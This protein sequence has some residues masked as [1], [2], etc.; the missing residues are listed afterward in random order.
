MLLP[1]AAEAAVCSSVEEA[2]R[3]L[4]EGMVRRQNTVTVTCDFDLYKSMKDIYKEALKYGGP[5]SSQGVSGDYLKKSLYGTVKMSGDMDDNDNI[6][7]KYSL[8]YFTTEPQE[9]QL[10]TDIANELRMLNL[11][12]RSEAEKIKIIYDDIAGNVKYDTAEGSSASIR[13]PISYAA[14]GAL[15]HKKAVCQGYAAL[16]YRLCNESGI[17]CRIV[18]GTANGSNGQESHAWN[19]VKIGGSWFNVDV[20]WDAA[21]KQAG[22]SYMYFLKNNADFKDHWRSDEFTSAA[23]NAACPMGTSTYRDTA[24]GINVDGASDGDCRLTVKNGSG[25]GT[26]RKGKV[27]EIRANAAPSGM[28]FSRWNGQVTFQEGSATTQSAKIKLNGSATVEAEYKAGEASLKNGSYKLNSKSNSKFLVVKN[29]SSKVNAPIVAGQENAKTS[30]YKVTKN[31]SYYF[32]VNVKTKRYLSLKGNK[33]VQ[34]KKNNFSKWKMVSAGDGSFKMV[35]MN[36][37]VVTVNGS[38]VSGTGD[39]G[40]SSRQIR[41]VA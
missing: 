1:V 20:T 23:F 29:D 17:S 27:V 33:V 36:G 37:K 8:N 32:V 22:R 15:H 12:G 3:V 19:V 34:S 18:E 26:Y 31:G 2:G 10:N 7:F 13:T 25:S 11:S 6:V 9:S 39:G 5:G 14:Y 41:F 21:Y 38:T 4:R 40:S 16:F 28:V 24:L 30:R 35:N